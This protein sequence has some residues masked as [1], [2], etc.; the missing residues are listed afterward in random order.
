MCYTYYYYYTYFGKNDTHDLIK[1][2][3]TLEKKDSITIV[4]KT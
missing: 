4:T 2:F 3:L 1:C